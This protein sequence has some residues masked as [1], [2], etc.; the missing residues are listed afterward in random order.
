MTTDLVPTIVISQHTQRGARLTTAGSHY[1]TL[2]A[3]EET[4]GVPLLGSAAN[5]HP[6]RALRS[7]PHRMISMACSCA[8]AIPALHS[9]GPRRAVSCF[10]HSDL[11]EPA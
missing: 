10:L 3:I 7:I 9:P 4:Y 11:A 2:R 8:T 5:A 6:T 1:G